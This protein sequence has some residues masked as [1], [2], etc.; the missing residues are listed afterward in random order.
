MKLYIADINN[1]SLCDIEK[2][3]E[4]RKIKCKRYRKNTDKLRCI[5]SGLF[6]NKFVKGKIITES[7][8]KPTAQNCKFNLSH[9]GRYVLFA[10]S[11]YEV[12]C[13]IQKIG[14]INSK[15]VAKIVFCEN[16][17]EQLNKSID[18]LNTLYYLWTRKESFLKCIGEG[19]HRNSKEI[20][21]TSDSLT[22]K[23]RKLHLKTY[24]FADYTISVC[25]ENDDFPKHIEFVD[26]GGKQ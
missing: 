9:S 2:I 19:F 11:D 21:I 22:D 25:S 14:Y 23:K 12:G 24:S 10:I 3:S 5:A 8:G 16:E 18:K 20:D 6:E 13:D 7:F 17:K 1:I 15:G 26:L 4:T